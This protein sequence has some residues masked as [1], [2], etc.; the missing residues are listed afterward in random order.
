MVEGLYDDGKSLSDRIW[1][2]SKKNCDDIKTLI[3]SNIAK[4]ANS[5]E[6]AKKLDN[7]VNPTQMT[8]ASIIVSGMD[9]NI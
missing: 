9:R 6:L 2:K 3:S 5:R 1:E 8:K 4:G 7:Y